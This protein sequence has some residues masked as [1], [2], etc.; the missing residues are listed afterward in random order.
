MQQNRYSEA[1]F[2]EIERDAAV[3][4]MWVNGLLGGYTTPEPYL[5]AVNR[6]LNQTRTITHFPLTEDAIGPIP[7][8]DDETLRTFYDDNTDLFR[9]PER[10]SFAYVSLNADAVARPDD[11]PDAE[12]RQEYERS[13]AYGVPEKR[14]VQQIPFDDPARARQVANRLSADASLDAVLSSLDTTFDDVTLGLV[15]R[16]ELVDPAAA[17]AAFT[18]QA[19]EARFVDGRFGPIVVH[20]SEVQDAQKQPFSEVEGEI[21]RSLAADRAES[22]VNEM[23]PRVEDAVAGG[24]RVQ[25][26]AERF[27]LPLSTVESVSRQGV[28]PD[29]ERVDVPR[30]ILSTAFSVEPGQDAEPVRLDTATAWI[31]TESVTDARERPFDAVRGDVLVQWTE[32]EKTERLA[33]RANKA[34][35]AIETGEPV[36][37]VA[38]RADAEPE[39]SAPFSRS[40]PPQELASA[41]ASAAFEGPQ[42]HAAQVVAAPGR[43]VVFKVTSVSE[44]T[45]FAGSDEL[46]PIRSTLN[47]GLADTMLTQFLNAWQAEVGATQNRTVIEQIVGL[48]RETR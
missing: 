39:T 38:A 19:G 41:V 28:T 18:M 8:P 47:D 30:P 25:E 36:E 23:Y 48:D 40:E 31:Q 32:A 35:S 17:E 22:R 6:Y 43:H 4:E 44:P 26:I 37:R 2:I 14:R 9:A 33:R 16:S 20:V 13:S 15:A 24:A 45:F 12:V 27:E 10:R 21:R 1:E 5:S 42:G 34:V 7:T 3:R 29:G 11:V 46:G